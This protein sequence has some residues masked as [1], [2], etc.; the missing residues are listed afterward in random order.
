V[1]C[2]FVAPRLMWLGIPGLLIMRLAAIIDGIASGRVAGPGPGVLK[3]LAAFL[4]LAFIGLQAALM[5]RLRV[6][7]AFKIPAGSMIPTLRTSREPPSR[8]GG[9][10]A[11]AA[12]AGVVSARS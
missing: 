5:L 2:I 6:V 9:P 10:T 3:P 8:S 4:A 11:Q 1:V 7:E 12:C